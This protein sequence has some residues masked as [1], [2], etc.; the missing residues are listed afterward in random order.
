MFFSN[1]NGIRLAN[2]V[3][4]TPSQVNKQSNETTVDL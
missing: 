3:S 1:V 4:I 2:T